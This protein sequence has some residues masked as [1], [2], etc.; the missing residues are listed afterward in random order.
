MT[1]PVHA[2]EA[3]ACCAAAYS[4][5][6]VRLVLG[7]SYHPGGLALTRR[8]AGRMGL[9]AGARVLD[10]ASGPGASALLLARE[11]GV[12]VDGIDLGA[13]P[14]AQARAAATAA[15]LGEQ[16]RFGTG[17]AERIPFADAVFDAVVCE[18]AFC[19]FPSKETAARE[20]AR[21]LRPGG[22]VGITDV[23]VDRSRL[24]PELG[25]LAAWV[26]CIAD[27]R[28]VE[29]YAAILAAAGL[30]TV[31]EERHDAALAA[32]VEQVEAR[33]VALRLA[34][35]SSPSLA[36]PLADVDWDE[37]LRTTRL[38]KAAVAD[39]VAGYALLVAERT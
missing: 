28:P 2:D 10:V 23:T 31:L 34:A 14:V 19:T 12:Q 33:L 4:T 35:R 13:Q 11:Y 3:K 38:A 25:S 6:V 5:D 16:A 32:M 27:A 9:A 26:A 18:C 24:S 17:D 7:E 37:A 1:P 8:L 36:G 39:G 29:E 21:V 15:G 30:R 22:R 20:L